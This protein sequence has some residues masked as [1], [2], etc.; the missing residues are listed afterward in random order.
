MKTQANVYGPRLRNKILA[1]EPH[2]TS[3]H[4]PQST[5][6]PYFRHSSLILKTMVVM[7]SA[8]RIVVRSVTVIHT[9]T[10]PE[11]DVI[12]TACLKSRIWTLIG[13]SAID[14]ANAG[15]IVLCHGKSMELVLHY[16]FFCGYECKASHNV[17]GT[18]SNSCWEA[19]APKRALWWRFH[20]IM[21]GGGIL[22]L[23]YLFSLTRELE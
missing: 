15:V 10:F 7:S 19:V 1:W 14:L 2:A 18:S 13:R 21:E 20:I 23:L 3:D 6:P 22:Q 8:K 17:S 5:L 4:S 11:F 16:I 12:Q 9:K